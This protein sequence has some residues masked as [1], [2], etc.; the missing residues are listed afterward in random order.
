M[1][2]TTIQK[3]ISDVS[4]KFSDVRKDASEVVARRQLGKSLV[5]RKETA[6]DYEQNR[7]PPGHEY[8]KLLYEAC[9]ADIRA[10]C[11][12]YGQDEKL[13]IMQY[14]FLYALE[15][16]ADPNSNAGREA[17]FLAK[18]F[19]GVAA[20]AILLFLSGVSCGL[21]NSGYETA[22]AGT[23]LVFRHK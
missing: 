5:A 17:G 11:T 22:K 15:A 4:H 8:Y 1:T 18:C 19:G 6:R 2:L 21:F 7:V 3:Y 23:N 9:K 20:M 16:K 12:K 14:P 10:F 13:V